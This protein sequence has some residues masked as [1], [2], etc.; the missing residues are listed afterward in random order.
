LTDVINGYC[1]PY[2][3][4]MSE[5]VDALLE[6]K[7]GS[8]GIYNDPN[9]YNRV[10]KPEL[11]KRYLDEAPRYT[12]EVVQCAKDVCNYIFDTYGR[13]PAHVNAFEA[14]GVWVQAH[15]ADIG[16]YETF[17]QPRVVERQ[18]EHERLWHGGV[19]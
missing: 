5:A 17:Y 19:T 1:P 16:Y 18:V 15:H 10:L 4:T 6:H 14:P 2:Y 13:F 3:P 7:Y 9:Y 11:A 12:P 8:G